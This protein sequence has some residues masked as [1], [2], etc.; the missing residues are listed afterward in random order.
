MRHDDAGYWQV[1]TANPD[2]TAE[3]QVMDG[4]FDSGW[5]TWSA[6]ETRLAFNSTRDDFGGSG[7]ISDIFV[8]NADGTGAQGRDPGRMTVGAI[9]RDLSSFCQRHADRQ[10][11][12]RSDDYRPSRAPHGR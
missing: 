6:D 10:A 12:T 1:W 4:P 7:A 5:A 11:R 3:H 9:R 8:M 2:L